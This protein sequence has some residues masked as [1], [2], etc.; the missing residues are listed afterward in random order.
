MNY[1]VV[2]SKSETVCNTFGFVY[3]SLIKGSMVGKM[4]EWRKKINVQGSDITQNINMMLMNMVDVVKNVEGLME[5]MRVV[6]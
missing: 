2:V 1:R 5:N 4:M 3:W 6:G